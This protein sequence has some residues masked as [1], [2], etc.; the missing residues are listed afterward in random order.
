MFDKIRLLT[1]LNYN[2]SEYEEE[3]TGYKQLWECNIHNDCDG[4]P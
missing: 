3:V 4:M 1:K 2:A